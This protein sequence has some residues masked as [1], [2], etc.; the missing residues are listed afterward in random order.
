MEILWELN[1]INFE[2][3]EIIEDSIKNKI[4]L[5][6][7]D[8]NL[9]PPKMT[10]IINEDK[11]SLYFN[12]K[13]EVGQYLLVNNKEFLLE[14]VTISEKI[15]S[16]VENEINESIE[17]FELTPPPVIDIT[18]KN[19]ILNIC[20]NMEED[21]ELV[22][23]FYTVE[24]YPEVPYKKIEKIINIK[25]GYKEIIERPKGIKVLAKVNNLNGIEIEKT[26]MDN[27]ILYYFSN[28]NSLNRDIIELGVKVAKYTDE[29]KKQL[30]S[31]KSI[32]LKSKF[33][34]LYE[35]TFNP[36]LTPIYKSIVN[37]YCIKDLMALGFVTTELENENGETTPDVTSGIGELKLGNLSVK[38]NGS[39]GGSSGGSGTSNFLGTTII[40]ELIKIEEEKLVLSL[41]EV[42]E[43]VKKW[44]VKQYEPRKLI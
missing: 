27:E 43:N 40:E 32:V 13:L 31:E 34:L 4:F 12:E 44:G 35:Q 21:L 9:I 39:S 33:G 8:T 24:S 20:G 17:G 14:K 41:R 6:K 11:I 37:L 42:S 23:E 1:K 25:N 10:E 2:D 28:I 36:E 22:L 3:T 7:L 29:E 15:I 26:L 38:D 16:N 30:I 18:F 19:N 5:K